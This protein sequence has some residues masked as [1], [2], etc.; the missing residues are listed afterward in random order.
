MASKA[1][2]FD[3][4]SDSAEETRDCGSLLA[5]KLIEDPSLPR[6]ISICGDLGTGKTVFASGLVSR[7]DP[8]AEVTSPTYTVVNEYI[9]G[10]IPVY[11]FDVYR[12]KDG[13]DLYSTGYYDYPDDGITLVEWADLIGYALPPERIEVRIEKT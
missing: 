2:L 6:F 7:F 3:I 5:E 1:P 4:Y 8:R 10:E 9:G 13:D 12:I 11:H